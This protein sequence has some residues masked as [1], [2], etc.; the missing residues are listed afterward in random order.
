MLCMIKAERRQAISRRKL[1][2]PYPYALPHG[3][4]YRHARE[5]VECF[6]RPIRDVVKR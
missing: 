6:R 4:M 5:L 2:M 1:E 3:A